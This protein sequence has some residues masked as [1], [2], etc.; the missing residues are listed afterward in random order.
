MS[1]RSS[2]ATCLLLFSDFFY[3]LKCRW[4]RQ[5]SVTKVTNVRYVIL[6]QSRSQYLFMVLGHL[7][8]QYFF[9]YVPLI[10]VF[11]FLS[12][13]SLGGTARILMFDPAVALDSAT[14]NW[15]WENTSSGKYTPS[16]GIVCPYALLTVM[17]KL[18][19]MGNCFLLNWNGNILSSEGHN[20][21][22][23]RKIRFPAWSPTI[24]SASMVFRWNPRTTSLVPLQSSPAGSMFLSNMTGHPIL[25]FNT[26][27]GRPLGVKVLRNSDG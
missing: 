8:R 10:I 22:C 26:C 3:Y 5:M 7:C 25:S 13:L 11:L 1:T 16:F 21:I 15:P 17:A 4:I 14:Y 9:V 2:Y 27:G 19:L 20:E 23:G 24:I 6:V 18:S 12:F